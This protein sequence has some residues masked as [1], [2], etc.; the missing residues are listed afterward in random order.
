[1]HFDTFANGYSFTGCCLYGKSVFTKKHLVIE[2]ACY[3]NSW[4]GGAIEHCD[5]AVSIKNNAQ[6]NINGADWEVV[7]VAFVENADNPDLPS[8]IQSCSIMGNPS[9]TGF[10]INNGNLIVEGN[11]IFNPLGSGVLEAPVY[12]V[13]GAGGLVANNNT[14]GN[15]TILLGGSGKATGTD[16]G[17][18]DFSKSSRVV[19]SNILDAYKES[20]QGYFPLFSSELDV[21]PAVSGDMVKT[22]IGNFTQFQ[23]DAVLKKLTTVSGDYF[24]FTISELSDF[25]GDV[26]TFAFN[27]NGFFLVRRQ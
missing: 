25:S 24:T 10:A 18:Y 8:T 27:K 4:T 3:G 22:Q 12:F 13:G 7:R 15:H 9:Q 11:K 17:R 14:Y 16:F 23:I 21:Y 1:M 5:V 2:N 26:G 20:Y 6:I 19:D